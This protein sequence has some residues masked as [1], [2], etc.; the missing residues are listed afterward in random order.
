MFRA[1]SGD[2]QLTPGPPTRKR[3]IWSGSTEVH[4]ASRIVDIRGTT[5][6]H[7][8]SSG[9]PKTSWPHLRT[10]L[11]YNVFIFDSHYTYFVAY[12]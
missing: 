2:A 10:Q 12:P 5:I 6:C 3:Q 9:A 7:V 11:E 1:Y 8:G 4:C